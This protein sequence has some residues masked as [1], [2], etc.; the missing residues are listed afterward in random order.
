MTKN[1]IEHIS[2]VIRTEKC[3][4]GLGVKRAGLQAVI[5]T[6]NRPSWQSRR[7]RRVEMD[8]ENLAVTLVKFQKSLKAAGASEEFAISMCSMFVT[9]CVNALLA[10]YKK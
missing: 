4:P 6:G 9:A 5:C 8:F 7:N 2:H 10:T 3:M 1:G